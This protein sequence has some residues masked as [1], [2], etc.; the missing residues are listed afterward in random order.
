MKKYIKVSLYTNRQNGFVYI[1][2]LKTNE[3]YANEYYEF[4]SRKEAYTAYKKAIWLRDHY[5]CKQEFQE[6]ENN[7][8]KEDFTIRTLLNILYGITKLQ[9][10]VFE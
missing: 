7:S 10:M 9:K 1:L 4:N 5:Y 3:G 6:F 8:R 2:E